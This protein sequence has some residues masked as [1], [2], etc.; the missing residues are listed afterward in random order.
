MYLLFIIFTHIYIHIFFS[1]YFLIY[2]I[3]I[4]QKTIVV[5][6]VNTLKGAA[7]QRIGRRRRKKKSPEEEE[8][9]PLLAS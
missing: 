3:Y 1:H 5:Y 9:E 8:Q 4:C 2:I 6:D 7:V